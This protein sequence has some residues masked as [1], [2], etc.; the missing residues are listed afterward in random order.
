M[1]I[2]H[3]MLIVG[4]AVFAVLFSIAGIF[5]IYVVSQLAKF[6]DGLGKRR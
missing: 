2:W 5:C 1:D 6:V 4:M 3:W